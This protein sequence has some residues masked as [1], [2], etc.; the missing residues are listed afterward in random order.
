MSAQARYWAFAKF[1]GKVVL[2]NTGWV[3]VQ[4]TLAGLLVSAKCLGTLATDATGQLDVLG[5]DG[6]TLGGTHQLSG[7]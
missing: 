2:K 4:Q 6:H 5:H 1:T 7:M 3:G